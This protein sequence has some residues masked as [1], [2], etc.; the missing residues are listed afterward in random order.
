M[1]EVLEK[2]A[3]PA[4]DGFGIKTYPT[5]LRR[6]FAR[7]R[8]TVPDE[9]SEL[10]NHLLKTVETSSNV[11]SATA[12]SVRHI[13]FELSN[14]PGITAK[15]FKTLSRWVLRMRD[16]EHADQHLALAR[17]RLALERAKF[18]FNAARRRSISTLNSARSSRIRMPTM[19]RKSTPLASAFRQGE[20]RS[21]RRPGTTSNQRRDLG[22]TLP[23]LIRTGVES[24]FSAVFSDSA[25][26]SL[27]SVPP[28]VNNPTFKTQVIMLLRAEPG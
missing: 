25:L 4:P 6:F 2:V 21:H 16:Q 1:R 20:H 24:H 9:N 18:E 5:T 23:K 26:P 8:V 15:Q 3:A 17:E 11:D 27:F 28:W 12:H 13:A 19:K 14:S 10:A 7:H 22:A